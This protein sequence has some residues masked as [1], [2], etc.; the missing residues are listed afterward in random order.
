MKPGT[1][2]Y[3]WYVNGK[4]Q[5]STSATLSFIIPKNYQYGEI[6]IV[7][8]LVRARGGVDVDYLAQADTT[9]EVAGSSGVK[10]SIRA[11][12]GG[13][14]NNCVDCLVGCSAAYPGTVASN[15]IP[16]ANC[17]E[18]C[19]TGVCLDQCLVGCKR[20]Y[21]ESQQRGKCTKECEDHKNRQVKD[22]EKMRKR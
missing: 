15:T 22:I 1:Y 3:Y 21:T 4:A 8:R 2:G 16:Y 20:D 12:A 6:Q 11:E 5:S 10:P 9:L 7:A 14:K 19:V 17:R 18:T 13:G